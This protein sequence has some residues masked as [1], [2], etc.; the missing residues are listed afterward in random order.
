MMQLSREQLQLLFYEIAMSIGNSLDEQKMLKQC[1]STYL[2]KLNCGAS[3]IMVLEKDNKGKHN[4]TPLYALPRIFNKTGVFH[5]IC[6]TIP[7]DMDDAEL[8]AYQKQLPIQGIFGES[9]FY[10]IMELPGFGLIYLTKS[11]N[12][13]DPYILKSLA[14]LNEK[15]ANACLACRQKYELER[16]NEQLRDAQARIETILSQCLFAVAVIDQSR[17]IRWANAYAAELAGVSN[18]DE[19]IGNRCGQFLCHSSKNTCPMLDKGQKIDNLEHILLRHNGEEIPILKS[20]TH[21]Q[22]FGEPMQLEAFI[23]ITERKKA[24]N[25]LLLAKKEAESASEA[26]S[27]FLANMSH[28]LRTPM[29]AIL[30][31]SEILAI[32]TLT[33]DQAR[34][35]NTIQTSGKSLLTIINDILDYSMIESGNINIEKMEYPTEDILHQVYSQM[36][37]RAKEKRLEFQILYLTELPDEIYTN[38][39]RLN[40]CLVN[41]I[42][43]A[44]KFT[45]SGHVHIIASCSRE[46]GNSHIKFDIKDTGIGIPED[47][48]DKIFKSFTQADES[49]TRKFGG[50][51]LGLSITSQLVK[52]LGGEVSVKSEPGR[53]STFTLKLSME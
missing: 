26:K 31:F 11:Q 20:V 19:L 42:S 7:Q 41:L 3:G 53:G 17:T 14:P 30:G 9:D 1:L 23:D 29:N 49:N 27:Q 52:L 38:P 22:M 8:A 16:L 4:Y 24:E 51:G 6:E 21:I 2:R 10:H 50:T 48:I 47:K 40:Q 43:N 13:L 34:Y 36:A 5:H 44:I 18:P 35:V 12:D 32:E 37:P 33:D 46:R 45:E 25:E 15:L 28:E 39:T